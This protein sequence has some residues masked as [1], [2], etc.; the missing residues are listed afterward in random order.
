MEEKKLTNPALV[1]PHRRLELREY[2]LAEF[3]PLTH[4]GISAHHKRA[5]DR[6]PAIAAHPPL[7]R[8]TPQVERLQRLEREHGH[9]RSTDGPKPRDK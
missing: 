5:V 1:R 9:Q 8:L 2:A 4:S 3:Y 6:L 7:S